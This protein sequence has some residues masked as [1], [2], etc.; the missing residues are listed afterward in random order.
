MVISFLIL[1][2]CIVISSCKINTEKVNI[3]YGKDQ[4]AYCRMTISD[5]NFGAELITEKGRVYKYDAVE[6]MINN[7]NE[8]NTQ[9]LKLFAV[10][11]DDPKTLHEVSNLQYLISPD[12]RSPMGANLTSYVTPETLDEKYRDQLM[13]WNQLLEK[14]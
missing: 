2:G 9:F 5:P 12:Y 13:T 10:P 1:F 11:Y 6:C 4:C 14:L 8:D 3:D 7:I